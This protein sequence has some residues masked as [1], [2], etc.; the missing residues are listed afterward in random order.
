MNASLLKRLFRA[1]GEHSNEEV[2][3]VCR[4]IIK[5]A[6]NRRHVRLAHELEEL[7]E[8]SSKPTQSNFVES[9]VTSLTSIAP[10]NQI[11]NPM[12]S[13][14]R[15]DLLEH[16]MVLPHQ[17]EQKFSR[18]ECEYAARERLAMHGL[19]PRKKILLYGPPGCGKTLGAKRLA[20]STGLT[21]VKVRFDVMLSSMFG[22]SASNLR[23]I[24]DFCMKNPSL[25]LLDECDFIARSRVGQKDI[26]EVHRIVNTLLQLLDDYDLP[27][28][29]VATTNIS[30]QIDT[31][32]FR[33][34]DDVIEISKPGPEE[35]LS[36]LKMT[37]SSI[38]IDKR[39][40]WKKIVNTMGE[41]SASEVVKIGEN[42]SKEVIL[43]GSKTLTESHLL[44]AI[45][46]LEY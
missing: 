31:A 15:R 21:L 22:E 32:L 26:G 44:K 7:L 23:T 28:L 29:V 14:T 8:V 46:D 17:I 38:N 2:I 1:I 41:V 43:N 16:H 24:F 30:D 9:K 11:V 25:L 13:M 10:S 36:I 6:K 33:R 39:I 34:F 12:I 35:V 18:I 42:A 45:K 37:L 20:W 4:A 19:K 27:G 3:R 5:D 40:D